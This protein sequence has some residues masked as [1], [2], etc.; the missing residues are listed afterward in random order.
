MNFSTPVENI[1]KIGPAYQKRLKK[2]KIKTL[3]DFLYN[4]PREYK[5]FS[6]IVKIKNI[7]INEINSIAG[8]IVS[9]NNEKSPYKKMSLV[10]ALIKDD[11]ASIEAIWFNQPYLTS[12]LK[13]G[14]EVML[15]GKVNIN[16]YSVQMSSPNFEKISLKENIHTGRIVPIYS[17]TRGITSK[18]IRY[19]IKPLIESIK[20]KIPETLP[21]EI[22]NK[23][24]LLTLGKAIEKIHFPKKLSDAKEAQRRLVF[25][26]IFLVSLLNIKKRKELQSEE[27]PEIPIKLDVVKRF[28]SSLP[29]KLTDGQKKSTWQI[30]QDMEK[31]SPMNRLLQGDVGSGKTVVAAI[32]TINAI[33]AKKQ[34]VLMAPTEILTK[35]HFKTFFEL[36][37]N[38]N[39]NIG[40]LTGKEDLYYS[41]KLKTDTIEISRKRLIEKTEEGEINVLIGTQALITKEKTKKENRIRF[42]DLG[43]I[44]IDEQ[45]RFGVKQ[46]ASLSPKGKIAHL[47]SM[48][49]T[50]IPRTLTLTIWGDLD[51]SVIDKL[52]KGRKKIKTNIIEDEKKAYSL[53]KKEVK[54]GNQAF[55]ICPR[56]ESVEDDKSTVKAVTDEY[57]KL[58]QNIFPDLKVEMLHGKMTPKEKGK[59]MNDFKK[60]KFNILVST[61]VVEVGID[62][63]NA[64]VMMIEGADRFGLA[65]LHQFRGRVGRGKKQS[66]CF[67]L[68]ESKS[69]ATIERI[70]AMKKYD[71]G[72]KLSEIDLK[73]RG[74]GDFLG[75]RQW[76][77]PDYVMSSLD[78]IEL[79][80]E[81]REASEIIFPKLNS[82]PKLKQRL[83]AFEEALHLE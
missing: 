54:K 41:K 26:Q 24:K 52:P 40:F 30:L 74:P 43:L 14:D 77:L 64:T 49:A 11:T 16:K 38:F 78:N 23:Y 17:E 1:P 50:P 36:L 68:T 3:A 8:K 29:F 9:I 35:Q 60:K 33:K 66:Y 58:S 22:I 32:A 44:I 27:A 59:I 72:F 81:T 18:W 63:P 56:I 47:L 51:L 25:E 55:V 42:K 37:K 10:K 21:E 79:L 34:V 7:K 73:L 46:R 2:L 83:E 13:E 70:N 62:I 69:K 45:H 71:S 5:D 48:T 12:S 28:T 67:L 39:V 65:Q 6:E 15:S 80:K 20:D 61:S 31:C 75:K 76:G 82:Y 57:E 19:A 4:F 53:I